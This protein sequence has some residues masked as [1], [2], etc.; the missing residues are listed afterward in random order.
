MQHPE[1]Q[2]LNLVTQIMSEGR[3]KGDRTGTGTQ[4]IFGAQ[5]R[6]DLSKGFPLLTTK[7]VKLR[8]IIH[9]LLWFL[10]GKTNADELDC[11]IW[12]AWKVTAETIVMK[13]LDKPDREKKLAIKDVLDQDDIYRVFDVSDSDA[14]FGIIK[15]RQALRDIFD[16]VIATAARRAPELTT[17]I[18]NIILNDDIIKLDDPTAYG[19]APA[20]WYKVTITR[21]AATSTQHRHPHYELI[22]LS[23]LK[24]KGYVTEDEYDA[25]VVKF[26]ALFDKEWFCVHQS[27]TVIEYGVKGYWDIALDRCIEKGLIPLWEKANIGELGP[28]Y[29][30]MWRQW[31]ALISKDSLVE[32]INK[33]YGDCHGSE[34]CVKLDIKAIL[35]ASVTIDQLQDVIVR[36]KEQ[37]DCRRMLVSG[38]NPGLIPDTNYSPDR[39][40]LDGKQ[41]LPPCHTMFQFYTDQLTLL[42][43]VDMAERI[44]RNGDGF[45]GVVKLDQIRKM[46]N[47]WT[48]EAADGNAE[49]DH[50]VELHTRLIDELNAL[51]VPKRRLSCQLYMRS[52]DLMLGA[53]FN[54]ASYAL[55]TMIIARQVGMAYGDFIW[56]GGDVHI[57]NNHREG[58]QEQ[59]SRDPRPFPTLKINRPIGTAFDDY[60]PEDFVLENY[61]PHPAIKFPISV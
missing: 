7:D 31:P 30:K 34:D 15:D 42:E 23:R 44:L 29:G 49:L 19:P 35:D 4:S 9:E 37:P 12:D 60:K 40:A 10:A 14:W 21:D 25:A 3:F 28:V 1:Y 36:L 5:M 48:D 45:G 56:S 8:S 50:V 47:N 26:A 18:G 55:L 22:A 2:Y 52:N 38:W 24:D 43:R 17:S 39:N 61:D 32:I 54:I 41:A 51:N 58:A 57:Y 6:F 27:D 59:L 11:G 13:W 16:K 53:P 46:Y 20:D 33:D